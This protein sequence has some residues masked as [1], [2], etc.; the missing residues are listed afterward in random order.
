MSGDSPAPSDP[1][2]PV[3]P[4]TQDEIQQILWRE[5]EEHREEEERLRRKDEA[6]RKRRKQRKEQAE[7]Q[8]KM[9]EK[10]RREEE[11]ALRLQV[12]K[13][14]EEWRRQIE[15]QERKRKQD[16]E[17]RRQKEAAEKEA[18]ARARELEEERRRQ[19]EILREALVENDKEQK[20]EEEEVWL[21]GDVFKMPP[22]EP[23]GPEEPDLVPIPEPPV[24]T[25]EELKEV[26]GEI[27]EDVGGDRGGLPPG[28]DIS[29]VTVT[30]ENAKLTHFPALSIPELKSLSLEGKNQYDS[31]PSHPVSAHVLGIID[32]TLLKV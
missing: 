1:S 21:R 7:K 6:R 20:E 16:E 4:L 32:L 25:T 18:M 29:D 14:E 23:E 8:R 17:D 9:V 26:Q 19:E 13:E 30:C 15:E 12:E 11:E 10:R 28:C 31:A 2:E 24:A 22:K 5:E 27:E 3:T